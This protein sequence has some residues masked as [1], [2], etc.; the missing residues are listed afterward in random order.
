MNSSG[1]IL[2][3]TKPVCATWPP[4]RTS[5][6]AYKN[7]VV[8]KGFL[9]PNKHEMIIALKSTAKQMFTGVSYGR[10]IICDI[11]TLIN[12]MPFSTMFVRVRD[13]TTK[14]LQHLPR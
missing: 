5:Y 1:A 7:P 6:V 2:K 8:S 10:Y 3:F 11:K 13:Q 14:P 4:N 12:L 9:D